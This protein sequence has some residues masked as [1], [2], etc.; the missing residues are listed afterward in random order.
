MASDTQVQVVECV[1][2][3]HVDVEPSLWFGDDHRAVLNS[4]IDG[5]DVL[6]A[7]FAGGVLR[8]QATSFVG[9][10]PIN[11]R[12]VLRVR[13]RVP[14][15]SLTRMVI[16]TGHGV[17]ALSAV[18]D[19]AGRGPADEWVMDRYADA[20]LDYVDEVLEAGL[21]RAYRQRQDEGSTPHGRIDFP[22]TLHRF[23]ARGI[24]NQSAFS[25]F[26]RTVD[27]PANRCI[28]AAMEV[29]YDH[30]TKASRKP[31][32]GDRT[33]LRRLS[34]QFLPFSEVADDHE[35]HFLNDPQVLNLTPLPDPRSYYRPVLDLCA[36][37]VRGVGITLDLGGRD[38][39]MGSLLVNTNELFEKFVRVNLSKFAR[40]RRLPIDVLD[41]NTEGRVDLYDIPESWPA[42]LGTPL[43]PLATRD[44]G[45]AQP[46][47]VLR[48]AEGHVTLIAEIKNTPTSDDA[49]PDRAHMEQAVTYA[50]RYGLSFTLLIHP[51]SRG[52]KGLVYVGRVR[53]IDVY[54]YRLDLSDEDQ[55]D[56]ALADM[57]TAVARLAGVLSADQ[58]F[59]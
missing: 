10:I 43:R 1:E 15:K 20:L 49:L 19:Y 6:R 30:L 53:S 28:K 9:V 48:S 17:M 12:V 11:D 5:K 2:Y 35:R 38:V 54:D 57:G 42:P 26:E 52:T 36:L 29:I 24:P 14:L 32:K 40:T 37:I 22:L 51:W 55:T 7:H 44:A 21:L 27:T 34:G 41:G 58:A 50:L 33:R 3:G 25:W 31:R 59:G 46:D 13:P 56:H 8:L 16:E 47:V 39:R 18:R 23:A 4:E 45:K